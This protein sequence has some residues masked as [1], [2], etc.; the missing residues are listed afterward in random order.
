MKEDEPRDTWKVIRL[1]IRESQLLVV[2]RRMAKGLREQ[3]P[4]A[5]F[6]C[7]TIHKAQGQTIPSMAT[8]ISAST[9]GYM[10]WCH[11][12]VIV[13]LS[14]VTKFTGLH[15]V[16]DGAMTKDQVKQDFINGILRALN[17]NSPFAGYIWELLGR[18]DYLKP[19]NPFP[20]VRPIYFNVADIPGYVGVCYLLVSSKYISCGYTG[21]TRSMKRRLTEHNSVSGGSHGTHFDFRKPWIVALL[22]VGFPGVAGTRQNDEPR[23]EF[24]NRWRE[25][26][27]DPAN[28][29]ENSADMFKLGY[30]VF[31]EFKA[32]CNLEGEPLYPD[33]KDL[34][35]M[36]LETTCKYLDTFYVFLTINIIFFW[37]FLYFYYR[38]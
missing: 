4:L 2:G 12:L 11:E 3:V 25:L 10:L 9:P 14:R 23:I 33:L 20:V 26:H 27:N 22:F 15:L 28:R 34:P 13:L 17:K 18:L 24:E 7:M 8:R 16:G 31:R 37:L 29:V 36:R 30:V 1:K 38:R 21:R 5:P 6:G 32:R 19:S 35:L